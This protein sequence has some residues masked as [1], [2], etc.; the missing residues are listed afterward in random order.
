M[1]MMGTTYK[2]LSQV[3]GMLVKLYRTGLFV[4]NAF[5]AVY[6]FY[7]GLRKVD[8]RMVSHSRFGWG[9][10]IVSGL[11][12]YVQ[13]GFDYH[14]VP[15]GPLPIHTPSNPTQAASVLAV[16]LIGVYLIF[17]GVW[18]GFSKHEPQSDKSP[19]ESPA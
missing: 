17:R 9:R 13:L 12:L 6:L 3:G 8:P 14:L 1:R 16:D 7:S 4:L 11:I 5:L 18:K 10:M 15:E 19:P 2:A